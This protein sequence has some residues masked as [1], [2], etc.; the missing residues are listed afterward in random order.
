[1]LHKDFMKLIHSDTVQAV[2][3]LPKLA[4]LLET[5]TAQQL[6]DWVERIS[7]PRHFQ[8]EAEQNR[9][10]AEWLF[11][12]FD[13]M[14]YRVE[15]QGK[16]SNILALPK[17]PCREA[18]L[19]GAHYDSVPRCPGADDNGS[20][21]AA[22]LGCAAACRQWEPQAAVLFIAF[23]REEDGFQGSW[24]FVESYVS[25]AQIT[26]R[27]AH[28]LEMVGYASSAPGSQKVPTGLPIKIRNVGDFLG[29]LAN[30]R[31]EEFMDQVMRHAGA[32]APELPVIGLSVE[33]GMEKHLPV[34]GRSDHVPFWE[35][36][37][38]AVM[39]TDTADFRNA[40]YHQPTDTP[41][42]LDYGF[43]RRVT[44]LLAA[45]VIAQAQEAV[46]G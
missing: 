11:E 26:L 27:C 13:S 12:V 1:V 38:P 32:Y 33:P 34:L 7:V 41:D 2:Q 35:H 23:N 42:T 15:R 18:I 16:F 14:G 25:R 10:T 46:E 17:A 24:D 22:M 3:P 28:V 40:N 45:S 30:G 43:L 39:W 31:S 36:D 5:V 37:L 21:V 29:L 9:A 20:A 8:W 6:R 44:Q 19:V 4:R